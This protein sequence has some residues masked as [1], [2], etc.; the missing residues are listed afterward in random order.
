MSGYSFPLDGITN[1]SQKDIS[2]I[3][4]N[5]G[6]EIGE[7]NYEDLLTL[8]PSINWI[9]NSLNY[10]I[11]KG[12]DELSTYLSGYSSYEYTSINQ[13]CRKNDFNNRCGIIQK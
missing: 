11:L 10:T 2:R 12:S 3:C 1:I 8:T 4:F 7:N 9:I 13:G 5:F 6:L